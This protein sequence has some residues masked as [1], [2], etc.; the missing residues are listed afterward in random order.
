MTLLCATLG[1]FHG[2]LTSAPADEP[3]IGFIA[4]DNIGSS[5]QG[6]RQES[7]LCFHQSFILGAQILSSPQA[8]TFYFL[9]GPSCT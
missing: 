3:H 4:G 6:S 7:V 9:P 1:L 8:V 5:G 2:L